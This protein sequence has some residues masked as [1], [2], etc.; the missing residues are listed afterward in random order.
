MPQV[1]EHRKGLG[2]EFKPLVA[3]KVEAMLSASD[4]GGQDVEVAVKF[5][6][7]GSW[8]GVQVG[9]CRGSY[10]WDELALLQLEA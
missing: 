7:D 8:E 10:C 4:W 1:V 3:E 6:F 5:V 2:C 9:C